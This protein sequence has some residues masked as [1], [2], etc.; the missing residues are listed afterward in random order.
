VP[1]RGV[2]PILQLTTGELL[3]VWLARGAPSGIDGRGEDKWS[4]RVA[5]V[6]A[7]T[8][9]RGSVPRAAARREPTVGV[10]RP[11]GFEL[12][13]WG[14]PVQV[15]FPR[16]RHGPERARALRRAL[17]RD[18]PASSRPRVISERALLRAMRE[19]SVPEPGPWRGRSVAGG[20]WPGEPVSHQ[21]WFCIPLTHG[22]H[23]D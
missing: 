3:V 2:H 1:R 11:M 18:L 14:I 19:R 4:G 6:T 13:P 16:R 10:V 9:P 5:G 22:R 21:R 17:P 7:H 8:V 15:I 20:G 12:K 23:A